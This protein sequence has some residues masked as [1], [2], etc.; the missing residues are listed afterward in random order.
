MAKIHVSP[1]PK[2]ENGILTTTFCGEKAQDLHW[3]GDKVA[4]VEVDDPSVADI[5]MDLLHEYNDVCRDCIPEPSNK[6]IC[7]WEVSEHRKMAIKTMLDGK[8]LGDVRK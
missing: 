3:E 7:L 2:P 1:L 4:F 8:S 6:I 5:S